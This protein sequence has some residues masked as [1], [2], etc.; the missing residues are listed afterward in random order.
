MK[1]VKLIIAA[2]LLLMG[3]AQLKAQDCKALTLPFFNYDTEAQQN[4]PFGKLMWRCAYAQSAFYT[5]DELPAGVQALN[6]SQVVDKKT[7][8]NLDAAIDI[9][10][11]TFSYYAYNFSEFQSR[12]FNN[13]IYF[14]TPGSKF[15]YLVVR[16]INDMYLRADEIWNQMPHEE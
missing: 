7:G 15:A 11:S 16:T 12:N 14:A 4:Y 1:Q 5:V 10:L 8:R 9:D 6:I 2:A 13:E 3:S